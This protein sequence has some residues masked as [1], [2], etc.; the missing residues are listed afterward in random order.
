MKLQKILIVLFLLSANI[1]VA[2]RDTLVIDFQNLFKSKD[3]IFGDSQSF[4]RNTMSFTFSK[5]F[6]PNTR[7]TN[8]ESIDVSLP[9][10]SIGFEK[11]ISHNSGLMLCFGIEQWKDEGYNY[12]FN[13][14]SFSSRY[15][16]HL[17]TIPKLDLYLGP[18]LATR[19]L[20]F[21]NP[22][23]KIELKYRET[24]FK[25]SLNGVLGARYHISEKFSLGMEYGNDLSSF[26]RAS[27][28]IRLNNSK[29]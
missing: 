29:K 17:N 2:Q 20:I 4:S 10:I 19:M 23:E 15:L 18:A 3:G 1:T 16:I 8:L 6:F 25:L 22:V 9:A 21:K 26:A 12:H 14:Y 7:N 27:V 24:N 11:G 28:I 5:D 13:Y